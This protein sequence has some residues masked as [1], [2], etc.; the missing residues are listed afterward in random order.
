MTPTELEPSTRHTFAHPRENLCSISLGGGSIV[1]TP[2]SADTVNVVCRIDPRYGDRYRF[3]ADS[4]GTLTIQ[5]QELQSGRDMGVQIDAEIPPDC[6]IELR[7]A[8]GS[9]QVGRHAAS[10]TAE[11]LGGSI[12][13]EK[14]AG[15]LAA[16]T[17]GG[18]V[19]VNAASGPVTVRTRGGSVRLADV[20]GRADVQVS[21]GSIEI[22]FGAN[23]DARLRTEAGDVRI[24]VKPDAAFQL[25]ATAEA[26]SVVVQAPLVPRPFRGSHYAGSINGGGLTRVD[27]AASA[28]SITIAVG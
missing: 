28:G 27:A 21:G 1:V 19:L 20:T 25:S 23:P 8:G 11:A 14:V 9:I 26:G 15:A 16:T 12:Q 4:N 13:I 18:R 3:T 6:D 5:G 22:A 7:T 17:S 2:A 10:I 24:T